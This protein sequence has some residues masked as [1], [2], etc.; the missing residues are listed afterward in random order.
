[1]Q[2][3]I[4][5]AA[6][7]AAAKVAFSVG[8]LGGCSAPP[9]TAPTPDEPASTGSATPSPAPS[10]T[11][12]GNRSDAAV[13]PPTDAAPPPQGC[14]ALLDVTFP[15]GGEFPPVAREVSAEVRSCC[16]DLL[17]NTPEPMGTHRWDCCANVPLE[18]NEA[19]AVACTPWGPP[20]PPAMRAR[21]R[22][23]T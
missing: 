4:H 12:T 17:L 5:E 13:P 16:V 1:M 19:V 2:R 8:V 15:T 9:P 14:E 7:R 21:G 22:A 23:I 20:V 10:S 11:S 18:E 6:L 3:N